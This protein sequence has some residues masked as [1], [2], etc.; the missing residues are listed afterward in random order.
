MKKVSMKKLISISLMCSCAVIGLATSAFATPIIA[1][2]TTYTYQLT[3]D[4]A[5]TT[6]AGSPYETVKLTQQLDFVDFSV[7]PTA[8][9][10]FANSVGAA[11]AFNINNAAT[12]SIY[13]SNSASFNPVSSGTAT[14]Q[15][16]FGKF[17]DVIT[18]NTHGASGNVAGPL[19][20][21]VKESGIQITD[22]T[23]SGFNN[24]GQPG[25]YLFSSDLLVGTLGTGDVATNFGGVPV[26]V[27]P[28][29]GGSGNGTPVPEPSSIALL[30]LGL[31]G[32][33]ATFAKRA[34]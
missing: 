2:G 9:N 20:F 22:F 1:V 32:L 7:T 28:G 26:I 34:K 14:N 12:F 6:R 3:V 31:I 23:L 18:L 30:A 29:G 16:P 24:S 11:F 19:T 27:V 15:T 4:G 17:N 8:G 5:S 33:L 21:M 10:V 25:G 13:G